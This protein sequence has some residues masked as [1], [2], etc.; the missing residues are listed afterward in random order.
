MDS[1][2]Q[3]GTERQA[4]QLTRLLVESGRYQ[5]HLACLNPQ[6]PLRVEVERLGLGEITAYPLTSFRDLNTAVQLRRLARHLRRLGV[7]VVHTHDFYTNVFGMAAATLAGVPVRIASRRETEGLRT[8][9][10]R[11]VERRAYGLAHAVVANAEAVRNQLANEGITPAKVLTVYN[12]LDLDRLTPTSGLSRA[13]TLAQLGLGSAGSRRIVTIVANFRQPVKDQAT[14]LRAASHVRERFRD[15]VFVLAGDGPLM[16]GLKS[17]AA[18]FGLADTAHFIGHCQRM[19]D[20]LAVSDVCA[21]SSRA[22][23]FSNASSRVHGSRASGGRHG[24]RWCP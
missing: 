11:W 5:I 17:L 10:Q 2:N 9:T 19:A 13:E 24:R 18:D 15:V 6:G 4:V 22:E 8:R 3:G 21:L 14:F 23:G 12:G 16:S 20:L 1:F 7:A